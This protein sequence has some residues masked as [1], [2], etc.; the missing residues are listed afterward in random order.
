MITRREIGVLGLGVVAGLALASCATSDAP[1]LPELTFA[2]LAPIRFNAATVEIVDL[3]RPP[4]AAPNV[5]HTFPR[6]PAAAARAWARQRVAAAG[7]NGLVTVTIHDASVVATHL[8]T[9]PGVMWLFFDQQSIR[10]DAVLEVT[11]EYDGPLVAESPSRSRVLKS[12]T[13]PES[14]SLNEKDRVFYELLEGIMQD[15]D[16]QLAAAISQYMGAVLIQA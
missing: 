11:I 13:V 1:L 5:E 2:H 9:R 10:Y 8:T 7:G 15:L 14:I 4:L 3:Y 6:S 12:Q 16:E